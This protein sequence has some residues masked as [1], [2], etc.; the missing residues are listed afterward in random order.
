VATYVDPLFATASTEPQAYRVGSRNGHMWC[1]LYGDSEEEL[2]SFATRLG[3][4]RAWGQVSRRGIPHYDLTPGRRAKAISLGAIDLTRR[5]A[6]EL[7]T[8][9]RPGKESDQ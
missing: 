4:K 6:R 9:L 8:Y 2:H 5:E 7:R 3:M 1:H